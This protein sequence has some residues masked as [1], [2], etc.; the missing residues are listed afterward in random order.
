MPRFDPAERTDRKEGRARKR[1]R[2]GV[3]LFVAA[4]PPPE[5]V[6]HLQGC[7][8]SLDLPPH[9]MTPAEQVHLTLLFL[10]ETP[11]KDLGTIREGIER[12]CSGL[13]AS[14]LQ[15]EALISLPKRGPARLIA[16]RTDVTATVR[17][18]HDRLA[19]RLVSR[20]R[21]KPGAHYLPHLTLCRFRKPTRFHLGDDAALEFEESS[22]RN[23]PILE[24]ALMQSE[25]HPSGARHRKL[26]SF[27][28]AE[29]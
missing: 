24:V 20:P 17:E 28:L 4:Y 8:E 2:D 5:L 21:E 25:L 23:F 1:A 3:R 22:L 9:R 11:E 18:L 12:A 29:G 27:E 14:V 16:A 7:L 26:V 10:G 13:P 19:R 6:A 15:T